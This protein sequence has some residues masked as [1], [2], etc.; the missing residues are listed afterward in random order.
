MCKKV[1]ILSEIVVFSFEFS[2]KFLGRKE[3]LN[4]IVL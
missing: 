1:S 2:L 3:K 4:A